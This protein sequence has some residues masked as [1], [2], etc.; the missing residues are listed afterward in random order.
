MPLPAEVSCPSHIPMSVRQRASLVVQEIETTVR[1]NLSES[2]AQVP[3]I[4]TVTESLEL[5]PEYFS[6][7]V[8]CR[9]GR[10]MFLKDWYTPR[11]CAG[12]TLAGFSLRRSCL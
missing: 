2:E 8:T 10:R 3:F 11:E 1:R 5:C 9:L 12:A 4:T 7:T 6:V